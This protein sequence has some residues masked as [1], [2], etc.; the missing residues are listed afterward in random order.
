MISFIFSHSLKSKSIFLKLY[1]YNQQAFISCKGV[2][3]GV[4]AQE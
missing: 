2:L 1:I 4:H 3:Q